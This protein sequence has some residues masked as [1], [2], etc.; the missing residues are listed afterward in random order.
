LKKIMFT[1]NDLA[2]FK[3]LL[4]ESREEVLEDL[5]NER[6]ILRSARVVDQELGSWALDLSGNST[7]IESSENAVIQIRR[8]S[9]KLEQL[10][11][12]LMRLEQGVYG[13][14]TRCGGQI[15]RERLE[16]ILHA[17]RCVSCKSVAGGN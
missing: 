16:A 4:L 5:K 17:R 11:A 15:E 1:A 6:E 3:S 10:S 7:G 2:R 14:C 8:L 9:A 13:L 12:A